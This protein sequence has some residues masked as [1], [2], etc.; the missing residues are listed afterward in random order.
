M[1][2]RVA[3]DLSNKGEKKFTNIHQ[4]PNISKPNYFILCEQ[5]RF[6]NT[7]YKFKLRKQSE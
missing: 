4:N 2:C 1:V 7:K 5:V 6:I 3:E